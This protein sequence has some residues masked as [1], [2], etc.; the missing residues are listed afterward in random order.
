MSEV[1]RF[2]FVILH[3]QNVND[4]L[5][6]I[7]SIKKLEYNDYDIIIVDNASP[8]QTGKELENLFDSEN[9]IYVICNRE[10]EG[11][12]KGNN[13][14]YRFAREKLHADYIVIL[15][16]DTLVLQNDFCTR[17]I[18]IYKGKRFAVLGPDIINR[19]SSHQN[20]HRLTPL[21]LKDLNRII[22]NRTIIKL[23]LTLKKGLGLIGKVNFVERMEI[24]KA[25]KERQ[26]FDHTKECENIVLQGSCFI[27]SADFLKENENAFFEE[28]FLY[29]E[30]DILAYLSFAKGYKL[31]YSPEIQIFHKEESS[32][33]YGRNSYEKHYFVTENLLKSAKVFKKLMKQGIN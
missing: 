10:N 9:N 4:T 7:D 29:F 23:Y 11:F 19:E 3:Y 5:E 27:F 2:S 1:I 14:G 25:Q 33:C 17:V 6:C 16:N 8:N 15:N 26:D 12:A 32:T 21:S 24:N 28:T 31:L 22:R 20:P 30:E 18:G 13:A